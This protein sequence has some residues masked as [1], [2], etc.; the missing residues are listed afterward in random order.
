[1]VIKQ[2]INKLACQ[3]SWM[4]MLVW[5]MHAAAVDAGRLVEQAWRSRSH[6]GVLR[7][8]V[9]LWLQWFGARRMVMACTLQPQI[10]CPEPLVRCCM[11]PGHL[12]APVSKINIPFSLPTRVACSLVT[13]MHLTS[14]KPCSLHPL[15]RAEW[16]LHAPF[17][18]HTN[19][20]THCALSCPLRGLQLNICCWQYNLLA[21]PACA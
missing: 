14:D 15:L 21:I 20:S 8:V 17:I 1:M 4:L 5:T 11:Q 3:A 2:C 16:C 6:V 10:V 19:Q 9:S 7:L 13:C 18:T 12:H